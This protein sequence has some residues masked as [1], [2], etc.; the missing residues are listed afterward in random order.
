MSGFDLLPERI[1]YAFSWMIFHSTWQGLLIFTVLLI[2][3]SVIKLKYSNARYLTACLSLL[4]IFTCAMMTFLFYYS[5]NSN[6]STES[7]GNVESQL[8]FTLN[9]SIAENS[10]SGIL[11]FAGFK[12]NILILV[13]SYSGMIFGMWLIGILF[14]SIKSIGGYFYSQKLRYSGISNVSEYYSNEFSKICRKLGI[15]KMVEFYESKNVNIPLML[16]FIKPVILLPIGFL[17]STPYS[18]IEAIIVHELAH[19]K[20]CD[21][22]VNL[23]QTF[24]ET[25]LFY[26]PVV[27]S[28]S[29]IIREERENCCDDFVIR[30]CNNKIEYSK[31]LFALQNNNYENMPFSI[32]AAASKR[33][34]LFRRIKRMTNGYNEKNNL[35]IT[36][37]SIIFV[38]LASFLV[39][40][41]ASTNDEFVIKQTKYEDTFDESDAEVD[42]STEYET[43]DED[44]VEITVKMGKDGNVKVYADGRRLSDDEVDELEEKL[45]MRF[46]FDYD[47]DIDI[48]EIEIDIPEIDIDI[49]EIPEITFDFE[50]E[51]DDEALEEN[52][53]H[54][55][56]TLRKIKLNQEHVLNSEK[57]KNDMKRLKEELKDLQLKPMKYRFD[58]D[59]FKE[60]MQK[61]SENL[62]KHKFDFGRL[63]ES[64][65]E[66]DKK[67]ENIDIDLGGLKKEIQK[68][69][70]FEKEVTSELYRDGL[71]G[72]EGEEY[73]L[74]LSPWRMRVDGKKVSDEIH[75]KY[76]K[77]Y[78]RHMGKELE[79]DI[80]F[81]K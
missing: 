24:I 34:Q 26:H 10:N 53:K 35:R 3:H 16:G 56:R 50:F 13:Q 21:Y 20:R 54:I 31:A 68:L 42:S 30:K 81:N 61:L 69:K 76:L 62:E 51:F 7:I 75:D 58:S 2:L 67:L 4:L 55:S 36:A 57:F 40:S 70:D 39:Y 79:G 43:L 29:S 9:G 46:D 5:I 32:L 80:R 22:V 41:C 1:L 77:I 17:T 73:D 66:L 14:L 28:I 64:L 48:P 6:S 33:N 11:P 25:I 72:D 37:A 23:I 60:S 18:H 49:P 47:F 59:K 12:K 44:D 45:N 71:I 63:N 19:I 8:S 52:M 74:R 78:E 15:D 38:L 27:W 65:A